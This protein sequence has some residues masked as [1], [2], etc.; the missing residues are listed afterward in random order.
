MKHELYVTDA[1]TTNGSMQ[2]NHASSL[3]SATDKQIVEFT[4]IVGANGRWQLKI[5]ILTALSGISAA[6]NHLAISFLA[7]PTDHWCARPKE[8]NISL[9]EWFQDYLPNATIK[10]TSHHSQCQK[11]VIDNSTFTPITTEVESC[12]VWEYALDFNSIIYKWDLVCDKEWMISTSQSVYM[13]G[14]L[15]T[16]FVSGQI[17]DIYGRHFAFMVNVAVLLIAGIAVAF[18]NSFIMF[19]LC[20]FFVAVG[21]AGTTLVAFIIIIEGVGSKQRAKYAL[22]NSLGWHTGYISLPLVAWLTQDWFALQL[23]ITLPCLLYIP[24]LWLL[25]ESPRWLLSKGKL[26]QALPILEEIAKLNKV[27]VKDLESKA[28]ALSCSDNDGDGKSSAV[29]VIDLL[30]TPNLRKKTLCLYFTWVVISFT[31]YGLSLNTNDLE[32]NDYLNF[33]ISGLLEFP[34]MFFCLFTMDF[35]GR[36]KP[37]MF[38]LLTGGLACFG[39]MFVPKALPSV[40]TILAMIGKMFTSASFAIIYIYSAEIF[41]TV[42]RNIGVGSSSTM[43][44]VGSAIAPFMR[45]LGKVTNP[46]VPLGI[47]GVLSIIN[48]GLLTFMPETNKYPVPETFEQAEN[49]GK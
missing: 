37:L 44:R 30:R 32:G 41:P 24:Y 14:F 7:F 21:Q 5:F 11:F 3:A 22:L 49:F 6:W 36:K 23:A 28:K 45:D 39:C 2:N 31:Y 9:N 18:A 8:I 26:K 43:A 42:A 35:L 47:F 12:T 20:R 16:V 27:E 34:A 38:C 48:S 29:T 25:P 17:S 4:D 40:S 19:A 15:F 10:G 46:S 33:F 1:V 13:L